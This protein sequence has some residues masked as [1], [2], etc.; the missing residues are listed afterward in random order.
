MNED[1]KRL[2]SEQLLAVGWLAGGEMN[3]CALAVL[4]AHERLFGAPDIH[5]GTLAAALIEKLKAKD[6]T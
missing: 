5:P 4:E 1:D 6:A 3:G 2:S